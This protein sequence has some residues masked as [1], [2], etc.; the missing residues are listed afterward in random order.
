M[1]I[2]QSYQKYAT[3]L[4]RQ[5]KY[6]CELNAPPSVAKEIK[7]CTGSITHTFYQHNENCRMFL[8]DA[9]WRV[10]QLHQSMEEVDSIWDDIDK[11]F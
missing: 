1:E 9:R 7:M 8:E 5:I 2:T 3:Q 6:M 4:G 10:K 11:L